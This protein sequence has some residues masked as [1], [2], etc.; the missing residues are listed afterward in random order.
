M[1]PCFRA[2][3]A[4]GVSLNGPIPVLWRRCATEL[5]DAFFTFLSRFTCV[6]LRC[7]DA[8][9]PM[10]CAPF[11]MFLFK[12]I[13]THQCISREV[14]LAATTLRA[15]K[16]VRRTSLTKASALKV[17]RSAPAT[18]AQSVEIRRGLVPQGV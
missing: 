2:E 15:A 3:W 14:S 4:Y 6:C 8:L 5:L 13:S 16:G 12:L 7:V 11:S 9:V 18:P 10:C 17:K 1:G